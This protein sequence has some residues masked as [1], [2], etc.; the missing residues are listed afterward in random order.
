MSTVKA[1]FWLCRAIHLKSEDAAYKLG[2]T[3]S[4][5]LYY[6]ERMKYF[7]KSGYRHQRCNI[8]QLGELDPELLPDINAF[9]AI[10]AGE[11]AGEAQKK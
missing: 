7:S 10:R 2:V 6:A 9:K 5:S 11:G 4:G 1:E 3:M 8:E